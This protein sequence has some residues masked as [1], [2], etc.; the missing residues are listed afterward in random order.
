MLRR[1]NTMPVL[2]SFLQVVDD[3]TKNAQEEALEASA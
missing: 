3:A 2:T 1:D